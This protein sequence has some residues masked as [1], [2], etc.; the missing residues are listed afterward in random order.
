MRGSH[1]LWP[2]SPKLEVTQLQVYPS[3][4]GL[5]ED[6]NLAKYERAAITRGQDRPGCSSH[7]SP[8]PICASAKRPETESRTG[9]G[10]IK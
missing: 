6:C 7:V 10:K 4:D 5:T 1:S 8:L 3:F 9:C 2:I